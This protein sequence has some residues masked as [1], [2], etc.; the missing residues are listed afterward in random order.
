MTNGPDLGQRRALGSAAFLGDA[1]RTP[2]GRR[3]GDPALERLGEQ[4][5][6]AGRVGWK[7]GR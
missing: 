7:G 4:T 3:G 1:V 2:I 6:H 5:A